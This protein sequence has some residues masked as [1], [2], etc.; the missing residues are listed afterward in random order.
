MLGFNSN[1]GQ[2]WTNTNVGLK[3]SFK[4]L[5]FTFNGTFFNYS[6][7]PTFGFVHI[8]P[9]FG[10]KQPSIFLDCAVHMQ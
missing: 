5:T 4:M 3:M 2:I 8:W 1:L 6:F 9:K 7:N 10:L